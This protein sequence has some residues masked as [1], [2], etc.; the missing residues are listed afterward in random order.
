M[1]IRLALLKS[2]IPITKTIGRLHAPFSHKRITGKHVFSI[3]ERIIPGSVLLTYTRGEFSNLFIPGD[4]THAAI[5]HSHKWVIEATGEG[6][7]KKDLITFMT[8]KD[9]VVLL[10]PKF[11]DAYQMGKAAELASVSIG[12]PYDYLFTGGNEAFYCSELVQYCYEKIGCP[13]FTRRERFNVSTVIPM[14]FIRA[15]DKWELVWDSDLA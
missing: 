11:C 14:D 2:A 15:V 12:S 1:N 10:D 5:A 4:F 9:R 8:S 7:R 13:E 6:V 3:M